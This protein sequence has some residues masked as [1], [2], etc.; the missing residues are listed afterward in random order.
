MFYNT[1][2]TPAKTLRSTE[3]FLDSPPCFFRCDS[4]KFSSFVYD[5]KK[6]RRSYNNS[7]ISKTKYFSLAAQLL[8]LITFFSNDCDF[9]SFA[10]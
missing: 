7:A 3:L 6:K 2:K 10:I 9:L 8:E 5:I 4:E 1:Y